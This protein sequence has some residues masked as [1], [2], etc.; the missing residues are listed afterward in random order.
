MARAT[1]DLA[2]ALPVRVPPAD[3]GRVESEAHPGGV[4]KL[5]DDPAHRARNMPDQRRR[6]HDMV[7][8]G[9]GGL[10]VHVDDLQVNVAAE[11]LVADAVH[12]LDGADRARGHPIDVEGQRPAVS[13]RARRSSVGTPGCPE[14]QPDEHA[15]GVGQVAD[16][17]TDRRGSLR[18]TVGTARI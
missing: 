14:L 17:L 2:M 3:G 10:L 12:G 18:T 8:P 11:L 7:A 16:E 6:G 5:A 9:Q 13:R 1:G 15:L 4:V